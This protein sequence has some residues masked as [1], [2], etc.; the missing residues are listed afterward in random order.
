MTDADTDIELQANP[1]ADLFTLPAPFSENEQVARWYNEIIAR[2]QREA[3]GLPMQTNQI[4]LLERIAFFYAVMRYK[5]LSGETISARDLKDNNNA[6]LSM[7]DTFNRSIEKHK[8]QILRDTVLQIQGI[9]ESVLEGIDD[10]NTRKHLHRQFIE[11]FAEK[12]L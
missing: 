11:G 8:D 3:A 5:E 4:Q 6:W 7:L 9:I 10:D 1:L 2:M 12:G